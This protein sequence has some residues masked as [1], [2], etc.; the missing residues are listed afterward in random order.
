MSFPEAAPHNLVGHHS[1][2]ERWDRRTEVPGQRLDRSACIA[3]V[4]VG[5]GFAGPVAEVQ[6]FALGSIVRLAL[7]VVGVGFEVG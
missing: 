2:H 3:V 6:A 5:E 7:V 1:Q 4:A